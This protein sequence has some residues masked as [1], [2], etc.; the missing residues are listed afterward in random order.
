MVSFS[1][2]AFAFAFA[3]AFTFAIIKISHASS[4]LYRFNFINI[5]LKKMIL[6]TL[7]DNERRRL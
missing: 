6:L 4:L 2:F 3:F 1:S 7:F 5:R